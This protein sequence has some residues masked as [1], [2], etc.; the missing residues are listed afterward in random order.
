MI[1]ESKYSFSEVSSAIREELSEMN[2]AL[3]ITPLFSDEDFK[4]LGV[5]SAAYKRLDN[6]S[7]N[8]KS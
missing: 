6:K 5:L 7:K 8:Q 1:T 2:K 4:Y 3:K